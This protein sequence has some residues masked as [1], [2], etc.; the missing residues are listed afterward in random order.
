MPLK[1]V[2]STNALP[3]H[4]TQTKDSIFSSLVSFIFIDNLPYFYENSTVLKR[5]ST[6][7]KQ[8]CAEPR[9]NSSRTYAEISRTQAKIVPNLNGSDKHLKTSLYLNFIQFLKTY[10]SKYIILNYYYKENKPP[11][12]NETP[13]I[14]GT[15]CKKS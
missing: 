13:I 12:L 9:R 8:K 1:L 6:V 5:N 4:R 3:F 2:L 7:P 14:K 15:L 10:V 11:Y